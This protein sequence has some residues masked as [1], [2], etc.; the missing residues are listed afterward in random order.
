[1][2]IRLVCVE[3]VGVAVVVFAPVIATLLLILKATRKLM[4]RRE[5]PPWRPQ[6]DDPP[7]PDQSSGDR[8]PRRPLT[9]SRSGAVSLPLPI[10]DD[11]EVHEVAVR[12]VEP[13]RAAGGDQRLAG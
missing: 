5:L 9:P 3:A 7:R 11:N 6:V 13:K 8:E 10:E 12:R 4:P 1:M 2:Q